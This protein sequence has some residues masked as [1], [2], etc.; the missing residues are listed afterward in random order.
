MRS[1]KSNQPGPGAYSHEGD[2]SAAPYHS[3]SN[4][5]FGKGERPFSKLKKCGSGANPGPGRYDIRGKYRDGGFTFDQ[6]GVSVNHRHGWYY[7]PDVRAAR[8]KPGPGSYNPVYPFS[9]SD[10]KFS[11][12]HGDRPDVQIAGSRDVPAPGQYEIKSR[13]GGREY[14]FTTTRSSFG[15]I[16]Q[17]PKDAVVGPLCGQPTQFSRR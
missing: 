16:H 7:D 9:K 15:S 13:L 10:R 6:K 5:T 2:Y 12:G 11:F 4:I 8:G 17:Q 3:V 1:S 14:S